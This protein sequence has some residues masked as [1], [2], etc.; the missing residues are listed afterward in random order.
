MLKIYS[1]ADSTES[2]EAILETTEQATV[3]ITDQPI[4]SPASNES[5]ENSV[6]ETPQTT[7]SDQN[8][9]ESSNEN[10]SNEESDVAQPET[11]SDEESSEQE[12][13]AGELDADSTESTE[14]AA[15][16]QTT[17]EDQGM[18]FF[19]NSL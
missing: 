12:L 1:F 7:E 14:N 13:P 8:N 16:E 5:N 18:Q 11:K 3:E 6:E 4:E 17:L 19:F 15:D 2:D 9:D 10:T